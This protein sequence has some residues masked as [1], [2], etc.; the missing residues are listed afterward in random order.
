MIH[1]VSLESEAC[2]LRWNRFHNKFSGK[3]KNISLAF[4]NE[5]QNKVLKTMWKGFGSNLSEQSASR[6][7]KALDSIEDLMSSFDTDRRL[8]KKAGTSF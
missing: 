5:Q 6:M 1:P 8:E 4:N 3:S 7:A 2:D